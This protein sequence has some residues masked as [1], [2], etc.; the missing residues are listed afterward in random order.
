MIPAKIIRKLVY[1]F[2]HIVLLYDVD[3]TGLESS[4]KHRQQLTEYGVK[5]AGA[6]A[7]G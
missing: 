3:K 7:D 6:A 2:K 1:R 5:P 4:E